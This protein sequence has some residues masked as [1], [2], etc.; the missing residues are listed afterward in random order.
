MSELYPKLLRHK[1]QFGIY[2][3]DVCVETMK[4]LITN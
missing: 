1:D 3:P 4:K 2:L